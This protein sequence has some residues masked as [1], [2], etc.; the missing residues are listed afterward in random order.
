VNLVEIGY[1]WKSNPVRTPLD[2]ELLEAKNTFLPM[3]GMMF[4]ILFAVIVG[5]GTF[6]LGKITKPINRII[7]GLTN[8][9]KYVDL[10]SAQVTSASK[11]LSDQAS[12]Q[13]ASSSEEM[14]D[15]CEKNVFSSVNKQIRA[16][17]SFTGTRQNDHNLFSFVFRPLGHFHGSPDRG[18]G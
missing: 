7:H 17:I 13:A 2:D 4:C 10:G 12:D 15:S 8:V 1:L 9:S 18:P 11:S 14:K 3:A 5:G 6:L 16:Q